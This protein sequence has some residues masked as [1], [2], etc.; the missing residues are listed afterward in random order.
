MAQPTI[1]SIAPSPLW[2]AGQMVTIT[3]TNFQTWSI[4]S[5][6]SGPL[7][8]PT[9][10]VKVTVDGV[11]CEKVLVYSPTQ[12]TCMVPGHDPGI[13]AVVVSN[14]DEDGLL[15][16]GE[17]STSSPITYKHPALTDDLDLLR[18]HVAV[19]Q[20]L[21]QQIL[22]NVVMFVSVD[23]AETPF[24]ATMLTKVPALLLSGPTITTS[25]AVYVQNTD[26]EVSTSPGFASFE[27][28]EFVDL[29]YDLVGVTNN[30][31]QLVNLQGV[32]QRF[33]RKTRKLSMPRDPADLSKG[34]VTYILERK[35]NESIKATTTPNKQDIHSFEVSFRLIGVGAEGLSSFPGENQTGKGGLADQIDVISVS[36]T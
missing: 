8:P 22:D 1:S 26:I 33:F 23:Y 6:S 35:L 10:T 28:P 24:E 16:S 9:P 12:L 20:I 25:D 30:M 18:A 14:I 11:S 4:P 3:G 34:N 19:V 29:E 36:L 27:A 32:M 21:R 15:I 17:A 13:A 7:P 2:S 31:R 5:S